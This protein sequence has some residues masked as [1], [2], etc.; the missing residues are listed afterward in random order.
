MR[1][2][3]HV[4]NVS[5]FARST[6]LVNS[7]RGLSERQAIYRPF[8]QSVPNIYVI[9]K[10][11]IPPCKTSCPIKMDVQGYIALIRVGKLKEAYA[12]MRKTNPLPGICGRVCYHPCEK[13]CKRGALDEPI[14]ILALKRYIAD[15]VKEYS[16]T[17]IK[18]IDKSVAII[19]S[20]PGGLTA[21]HDLALNG[22]NVTI[23][24]SAQKPGGMLRTGIPSYRLPKDILDKE[25]NDIEK[26]GV[27]IKTNV[28][29][30]TDKKLSELKREF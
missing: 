21:A 24:E 28:T 10:K 23:F 1:N 8:A 25:I 12:L 27:T 29:I 13:A 5:R 19:G 7:R 30:G 2:A 3:P 6:S 22:Y 20:G 4:R 26:L 16:P 18:K 14:A 9:D 15:R 17:N 11:E